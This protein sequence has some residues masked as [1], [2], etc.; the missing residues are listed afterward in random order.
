MEYT[1]IKRLAF[2]LLAVLI[3][4]GAVTPVGAYAYNPFTDVSESDWY[5]SDVMNAVETGLINGTTETT[6]CPDDNLTYAQAVKLAACLNQ[7]WWNGTVT[8]TNG[9]PWYQ[10]YVDYARSSGIL[11]V[12]CDW[13]KHITRGQFLSIFANALP[14]DALPVINN[15]P[16]GSIPDVSSYDPDAAEIYF[17]YRAGIVQ[18]SDGTHSCN[19]D[20]FI[21]RCEVAAILTRMVY[22][23][24]RLRF[25]TDWSGAQDEPETAYFV[26][27]EPAPE[28]ETP[29][30]WI[31]VDFYDRDDLY[32]YT[33][34]TTLGMI[35]YHNGIELEDGE[36]PSVDLWNDWLASDMTITVDKYLYVEVNERQYVPRTRTEI[37]VDTIPRGEVNVLV[38]GADGESVMHYVVVYKNGAEIDRWLSWEE[39]ITEMV[40]EQVEIGVGGSIVGKDGTVYTYSWRKTCMATYYNLYNYTYSG[41]YVST[42]TVATNL[43]YI[44]IGTRMY[45]RNDR[46]DFGYRV[47]EDTGNLGPWHV[48]IWMPDDDPNAPLMSV[49]GLVYDMEVYFLD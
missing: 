22:P 39:V 32:V 19:P 13:S 36:V 47:S 40:P 12:D 33:E 26:P 45:I 24:A 38:P 18:G 10:T 34:A 21:R 27:E 20:G 23:Y 49:E 46:Y 42:Q 31:T 28:P 15:V 14:S 16:D 30:Y 9:T 29:K 43:D 41:K 4:A 48:D 1:R 17:L 6:F 2:L 7:L 8:L 5:Y 35:L 44:P 3:F 37:G 11:Y 25:T